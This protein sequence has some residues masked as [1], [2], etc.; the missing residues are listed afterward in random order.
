M[1]HDGWL[2]PGQHA[3][4]PIRTQQLRCIRQIAFKTYD[5]TFKPFS[6]HVTEMKQSR[7]NAS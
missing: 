2:F 7:L 6:M 4:K 3:L 1:H 5:P